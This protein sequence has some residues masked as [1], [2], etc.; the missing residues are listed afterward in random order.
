MA[1]VY[2][3]GGILPRIGVDWL[4]KSRLRAEFIA[5]GRQTGYMERIPTILVD[6]PFLALKGLRQYALDHS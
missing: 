6:D 4:E 2:F 5:K 3:T 1:G